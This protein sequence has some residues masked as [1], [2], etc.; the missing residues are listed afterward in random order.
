ME[1]RFQSKTVEDTVMFQRQKP[2]ESVFVS[3]MFKDKLVH[4]EALISIVI[5]GHWTLDRNDPFN[6][7][8]PMTIDIHLELV[9]GQ[10]WK[11]RIEKSST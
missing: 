4:L 7:N 11:L 8:Q 5:V 9:T 1:S 10:I 6:S 2:E 3:K